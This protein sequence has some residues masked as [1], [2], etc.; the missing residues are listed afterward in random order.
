MERN[1]LIQQESYWVTKI[2][3]DLYDHINQYMIDNK[4]DKTR[5]AEKLGISEAHLSQVLNGDFDH[6]LSSY[7]KLAMAIGK[8]PMVEFKDLKEVT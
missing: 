5:F 8:V 7:V 6:K 3:L 4:L 2:Q 1:E